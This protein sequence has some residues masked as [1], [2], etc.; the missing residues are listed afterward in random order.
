MIR[1]GGIVLGLAAILLLALVLDMALQ[2]SDRVGSIL[3]RLN[4]SGWF[5]SFRHRLGVT[6]PED[7]E[8]LLDGLCDALSLLV[9]VAVVTT[10]FRWIAPRRSRT[11]RLDRRPG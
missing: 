1:L 5:I 8:A 9:S 2:R 4:Q 11:G 6:A 7:Q 10:A 3:H